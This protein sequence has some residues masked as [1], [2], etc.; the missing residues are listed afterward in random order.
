MVAKMLVYHVLAHVMMISR[1]INYGTATHVIESFLEIENYDNIII[2]DP[3]SDDQELHELINIS[4]N[5]DIFIKNWN[6]E[7]LMKIH[8]SLMFFNAP[9][10]KKLVTLLKQPGAQLSLSSNTWVIRVKNSSIE[11]DHYFKNNTLRIGLRA[12]I[13][14]VKD[15]LGESFLYQT[16]GLGNERVSF[17]V[18]LKKSKVEVVLIHTMN[19]QAL[20]N[21]KQVEFEEMLE[22]LKK[23][24]NFNGLQ[25]YS[26]FAGKLSSTK[27]LFYFMQE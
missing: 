14:F 18:F 24:K 21:I 10:Y 5:Y 13:F 8:N 1:L 2:C 26:N 12:H 23:R 19:F 11:L 15:I 3:A 27:D 9:E 25:F 4:Q 16:L 22:K 20:G 17:K 7:N 6:C